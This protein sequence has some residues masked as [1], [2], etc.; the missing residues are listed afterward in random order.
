MTKRIV[1]ILLSLAI[2]LTLV[3]G[4]G[5]AG[6]APGLLGDT[7]GDGSVTILDATV[8]QRHLAAIELLD[9]SALRRGMVNGG[10]ELTIL[11]ATAIQRYLAGIIDHFP[12]EESS[13]PATGPGTEPGAD[14]KTVTVG[15]I[16]FLANELGVNDFYVHY[17]GGAAY[18]DAPLV[19][20]P[21]KFEYRYVG[22]WAGQ[23]MMFVMFCAEI[24]ADATGFKVNYNKERWF[25]EDADAA[26]YN[27]AYIFNYDGDKALYDYVAPVAPPEEPSSE[28]VSEEPTGFSMYSVTVQDDGISTAY[29]DMDEVIEGASSVT[30]TAEPAQGYR[31]KGWTITGSYTMEEGALS[32]PVI[33]IMPQSDITAVAEFEEAEGVTPVKNEITVYFSN[34]KGWSKVNAY[35]YNRASGN[36]L[37]SW[38]GTQ[39]KYV[40]LNDE[41]EQVYSITADVSVYDRI[42]FNN[43]TEQTTDTPLTKASSGYFLD[44]AG[45][46]KYYNGKYIA[47]VYPY[48]RTDGGQVKTVSMDYPDGYKKKVYIWTPAGY[49][50]ADKSKKYHVLYMC[51]GQNLFGHEL[52]PQ[53]GLPTTLSHYEW[54]CDETVLSLMGNGG[55]GI[56]VVGVEAGEPSSRRDHELT[57]NLGRTAPGVNAYGTYTDGGG[58]VF[59]D[60]M[61]GTVIPY[62]EARYNVSGV[63]GIAGSSSGG[64]EA[65]YIGMEH[66]DTFCFI[67]ALS[68]AFVLYEKATWEN[69]LKTKDFSGD[70]PKIY[71]FCG[72][73]SQDLLEQTLYTNAVAMEGWLK[74]LGYPEER[75]IT[76]TDSDAVHHEGFWALYFAEMLSWCM[77]V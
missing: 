25:G 6:Q 23:Q 58:K 44:P 11:D 68:P 20:E 57:P 46:G 61:V 76:V 33:E 7:D 64:I 4:A 67:G 38:P 49:D 53:T 41:K 66:P 9:D 74:A 77:G 34:N 19:Q 69:Y 24:P 29:A 43:G 39:M 48:G 12:A 55:D 52:D 13:E 62:V 56:I 21:G 59:S 3:L 51:D 22:Y 54:E 65:F 30:L 47:G 37:S 71:F 16:G 35:V 40:G 60:F 32:D 72:N 14:A 42:I 27:K 75:M 26:V 63:R 8:I 1:S 2:V 45:K 36:A 15:V 73:S 70:M 18:G 5:A 17:W 28:P 31:F 10:A 50:P